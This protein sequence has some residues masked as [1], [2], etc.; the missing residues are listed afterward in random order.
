MKKE[1]HQCHRK[2][3][4]VFGSEKA[5]LVAIPDVLEMIETADST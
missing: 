5:S 3:L 1:E 4:S 2:T